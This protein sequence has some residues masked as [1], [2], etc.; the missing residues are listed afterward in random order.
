MPLLYGED[1][2]LCRLGELV[3]ELGR[4]GVELAL[5]AVIPLSSLTFHP[6]GAA[7]RRHGVDAV[8]GQGFAW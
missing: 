8:C 2:P 4:D 3:T 1:Y 7:L 5:L 6:G